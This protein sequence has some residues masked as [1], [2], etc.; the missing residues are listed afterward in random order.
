MNIVKKRYITG[1]AIFSLFFFLALFGFTLLSIQNMT[2]INR[3]AAE[4]HFMETR[5]SIVLSFARSGNLGSPDMEN[6]F[7]NSFLDEPRLLAL[8]LYSNR[9]GPLKVKARDSYYLKDFTSRLH[10]RPYTLEY[11]KTEG[12][13]AFELPLTLRYKNVQLDALISGY[14]VLLG[15]KDY[16]A[17][18]WQVLYILVGFLALTIIA[19]IFIAAAG[20]TG[21]ENAVPAAGL[22]VRPREPKPRA[23]APPRVRTPS[24]EREDRYDTEALRQEY[25]QSHDTPAVF[26]RELSS[27]RD[28]LQEEAQRVAFGAEQSADF[29]P[30]TGLGVP[31]NLLSRLSFELERAASF[32]QDLVVSLIKT[33]HTDSR[34]RKLLAGM[35]LKY[36]PFQDLAFEY[37]ADTFA[38][39]IPD[40]PAA[41]V[42]K[43]LNLLS[44]QASQNNIP[45]TVGVASRNGRVV[46]AE[47]LFAEAR[48]SLEQAELKTTENVVLSQGETD[49]FDEPLIP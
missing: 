49:E 37:R 6:V 3:D 23:E 39:I 21:R 33:G 13:K 16:T 20:G 18:L 28:S 24:Y 9:E 38:V 12:A 7:K 29:L 42:L 44:E 2:I 30:S 41:D 34:T 26:A 35:L 48:E 10:L 46:G 25:P 5:N 4:K 17:L 47:V 19:M 11:T 8:V 27:D 43:D 31:E 15:S 36:F 22:G 32:D 14:Y 45:L 1:Y 40:Q